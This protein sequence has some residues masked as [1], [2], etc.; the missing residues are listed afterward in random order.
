MLVQKDKR[1]SNKLPNEIPKKTASTALKASRKGERNEFKQTVINYRCEVCGAGFTHLNN[2]VRHH[3]THRE[4]KS[5][6]PTYSIID[7]R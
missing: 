2:L 5:N 7:T 6:D 1:E 4:V 3:K